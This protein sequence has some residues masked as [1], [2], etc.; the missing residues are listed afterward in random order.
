M[1]NIRSVVQAVSQ[2]A[3]T[4]VDGVLRTIGLAKKFGAAAAYSFRDIGADGGAVVNVTRS[5]DTQR[6]DF[7]AT[8]ITNG[9]LEAFIGSGNNGTIKI[10]YDQS[11]NG[12]HLEADGGVTREPILVSSGSLVTDNGKPALSCDTYE[13]LTV[14]NSQSVNTSAFY[15]VLNVTDISVARDVMGTVSGND[16]W[17]RFNNND[18][19]NLRWNT[20][21]HVFDK[22]AEGQQI[23]ISVDI[24]SSNVLRYFEDGS[25]S[26]ADKS[27]STGQFV[28]QRFLRRSTATNEFRGKVSEAIFFDSDKTA[29][30]TEITNL[31]NAHYGAF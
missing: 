13:Y 5:S 30:R 7:T 26:G 20:V 21:S 12:K 31:I 11:G 28:M 15:L 6:Q 9:T 22:T 3:A 25:Q 8:E 16:H 14:N 2:S 23:I 17:F 27:G 1:P 19:E 4:R 10:W 18:Y 24:D 29:E